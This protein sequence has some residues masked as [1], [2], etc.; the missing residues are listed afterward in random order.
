MKKKCIV[1]LITLLVLLNGCGFDEWTAIGIF[2]GVV[3]TATGDNN[4]G[5]TPIPT[6]SLE[7]LE[8]ENK[9][10]ELLEQDNLGYDLAYTVNVSGR[11]R[12]ENVLIDFDRMV[13][14]T[15]SGKRESGSAS[16]K[17]QYIGGS[18]DSEWYDL[19]SKTKEK[20]EYGHY[21]RINNKEE[22]IVVEEFQIQ[23]NGEEKILYTRNI[24][25][26][27]KCAEFLR[28]LLPSGSNQLERQYDDLFPRE[29]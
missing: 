15:V 6:K 21:S 16:I 4:S 5:S 20:N 28:S 23:D 19:D 3:S 13:K 9:V 10:T 18:K 26:L 8:K 22:K 11:D 7:T 17:T 29:P 2:D 24:L 12:F 25:D 1:V 14:T 27:G